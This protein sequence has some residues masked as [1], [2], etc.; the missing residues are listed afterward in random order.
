MPYIECASDVAETY[1]NIAGVQRKQ[2]KLDDALELYLA[3]LEIHKK[4]LGPK[5][6]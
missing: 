1:N 2:G 4:M 3:P 6:S 5:H